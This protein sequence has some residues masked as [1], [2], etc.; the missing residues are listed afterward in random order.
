M[1]NMKFA[2]GA[3]AL[4][5]VKKDGGDA[6]ARLATVAIQLNMIDVAEELLLNAKRYDLLNELYQNMNKWDKAI[7]I[8]EMNDKINLKATYYKAA[9][10]YELQKQWKLA[11]E[12]Y[13]KSDTHLEEIPRMLYDNSMFT[14][15]EEYVLAKDEKELW[16]FYAKFKESRGETED[17]QKYY[18]KANDNGSI[19][20]ITLSLGNFEAA[21]V[22]C[23]NSE[24]CMGCF[25][26]AQHYE[27]QNDNAKALVYY[28]KGQHFHHAMR[29][30]KEIGAN[31]EIYASAIQ[32][33]YYV[34]LRA[35]KYFEGE[36]LYQK[37]VVLY[38]KGRSL[39]KALDLAMRH[40]LDEY[41]QQITSLIDKQKTDATSM[42]K[43][44]DQLMDMGQHSKAF[45][46]FIGSNQISKAITLLQE[47]NIDLTEDLV[48]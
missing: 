44:G 8:A 10:N 26:L 15:L 4:R 35:A 24:D 30:A 28:K 12:Y 17:A 13:E 14:E 46:M 3:K 37:A 25:H 23:N 34:Q 1:A 20:R 22:V 43:L 45:A 11:I 36:R 48:K 6:D 29:L 18:T 38:M 39:K 42:D 9:N 31:D 32:A 16:Q 47:Q 33:P 2:R 21:E 5:E 40:K 19:V 41:I 7:E 27:N